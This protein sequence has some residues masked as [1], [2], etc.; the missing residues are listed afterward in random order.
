MLGGSIAGWED[1]RERMS[2]VYT[3]HSSVCVLV[4]PFPARVCVSRMVNKGVFFSCEQVKAAEE[5]KED[6][7]AFRSI[8]HPSQGSRTFNPPF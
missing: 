6:P 1:S 8:T 3:G 4:L 5:A 2:L 7:S